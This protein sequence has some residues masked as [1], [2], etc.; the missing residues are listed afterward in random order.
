MTENEVISAQVWR[1]SYQWYGDMP[2]DDYTG[3]I[4]P[5]DDPKRSNRRT[6]VEALF[7]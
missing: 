7:D 5:Y 4:S 2:E 3:A 6:A 1:A